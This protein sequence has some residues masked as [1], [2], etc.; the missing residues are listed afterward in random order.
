MAEYTSESPPAL[1]AK[2][3]SADGIRTIIREN[4]VIISGLIDAAMAGGSDANQL[5]K[6]LSDH[7]MFGD[8]RILN[9]I[10]VH[11]TGCTRHEAEKLGFLMK[12]FLLHQIFN[13]TQGAHDQATL[14]TIFCEELLNPLALSGVRH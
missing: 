4:V 13:R 8:Q 12:A 11:G 1:Q 2:A 9:D 10:V 3:L 5:S 6:M 14:S 7:V